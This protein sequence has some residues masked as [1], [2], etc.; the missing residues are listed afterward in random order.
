M[1]ARTAA[2]PHARH[3][4]YL[5][6]IGARDTVTAVHFIGGR[7]NNGTHKFP[8]PGRSAADQCGYELSGKLY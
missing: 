6:E 4:V 7:T 3:R 5:A 1:R 8:L 2:L